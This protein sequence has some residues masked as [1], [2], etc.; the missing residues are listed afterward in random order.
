VDDIEQ[1][2][3]SGARAA[4]YYDAAWLDGWNCRA[5]GSWG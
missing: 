4:E 2:Q 5:R 1:D 3:A